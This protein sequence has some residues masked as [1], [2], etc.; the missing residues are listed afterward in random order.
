MQEDVAVLRLPWYRSLTR[1]QWRVL[2]VSNLSW[3]FDG[4]ETD[5]HQG[6]PARQ[7]RRD[8]VARH[9]IRDATYVEISS[10][11]GHLPF[12]WTRRGYKRRITRF[13]SSYRR[14]TKGKPTGKK[15]R[16]LR[17]AAE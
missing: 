12:S 10:P 6:R 7:A 5:R 15:A 3:L 2:F 9:S 16:M 8:A 17:T 13:A 4:F 11:F 14:S 1:K